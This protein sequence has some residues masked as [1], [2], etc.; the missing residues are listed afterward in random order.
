LHWTVAFGGVVGYG[1]DIDV[2]AKRE[3]LEEAGIN[4][5]DIEP[6][7]EFKFKTNKNKV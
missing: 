4:Y 5:T 1:E 7:F 2:S 6:L 3:L